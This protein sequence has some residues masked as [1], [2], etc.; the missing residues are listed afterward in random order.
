MKAKLCHPCCTFLIIPCKEYPAQGYCGK[1]HESLFFYDWHFRCSQCIIDSLQTE[2]EQLIEALKKISDYG[3]DG[4]CPYG[5]DAPHIA[6]QALAGEEAED[7]LFCS[8]RITAL[9]YL[10]KGKA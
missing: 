7:D 1:Y 4:I 3:S 9:D 6:T 10:V 2:K 5:C 8:Q